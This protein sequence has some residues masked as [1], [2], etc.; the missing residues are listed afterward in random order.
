[1]L[2]QYKISIS[3]LHHQT[4]NSIAQPHSY[5]TG[6]IST[7]P[8]GKVISFIKILKERLINKIND[9]IILI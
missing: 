2:H 1:M 8:K 9:M 4:D 3:L 6:Q 7:Q 5:K